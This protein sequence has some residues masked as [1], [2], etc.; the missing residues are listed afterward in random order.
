MT[1]RGCFLIDLHLVTD[2]TDLLL[3]EAVLALDV[4]SAGTVVHHGRGGIAVA[5]AIAARAIAARVTGVGVV[6]AAVAATA[7]AVEAAVGVA[8]TAQRQRQCGGRRRRN[9]ASWSPLWKVQACGGL[10]PVR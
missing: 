5:R 10:R 3:V 7:A 1:L 2:T 8:V 4:A 6:A 9:Q